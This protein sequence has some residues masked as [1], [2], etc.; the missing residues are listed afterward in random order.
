MEQQLNSSTGGWIGDDRREE[1]DFNS[2]S[3]NIAKPLVIGCVYGQ[4]ITGTLF[5][6]KVISHEGSFQGEDYYLVENVETGYRQMKAGCSLHS[7]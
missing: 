4:T 1:A 7:L 3:Q 5:K 2:F 6:Y